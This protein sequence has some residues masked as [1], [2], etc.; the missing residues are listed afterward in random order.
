MESVYRYESVEEIISKGQVLDVIEEC[1]FKVVSNKNGTLSL[2][3]LQGANLADIEGEEFN[4]Y[5]EILYRLES[6]YL[7]DYEIVE[8]KGY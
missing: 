5:S 7:N 3:D 1:D 6:T 8:F 4:S 2:V